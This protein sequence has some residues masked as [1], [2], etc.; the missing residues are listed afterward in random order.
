V[1]GAKVREMLQG[2]LSVTVSVSGVVYG[3]VVGATFDRI[4]GGSAK[5]E[6]DIDTVGRGGSATGA[7]IGSL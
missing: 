4:G 6:M 1:L 2:K 5:V 3:K 7:V